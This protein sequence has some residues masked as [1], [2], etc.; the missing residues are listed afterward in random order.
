MFLLYKPYVSSVPF[1]G[2]RLC[3]PLVMFPSDSPEWSVLDLRLKLQSVT[4]LVKNKAICNQKH[5]K[6]DPKSIFEKVHNSQ[7]SKL[8]PYFSPIH[9]GYLII[10][11][12][13]LSDTGRFSREIRACCCVITSRL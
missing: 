9:N 4:F 5:I 12:S 8:P 13:N 11:F 7:C 2:S 6:K 3:F 1:V 10:M